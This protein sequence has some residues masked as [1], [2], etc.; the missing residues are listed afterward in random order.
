MYTKT[1]GVA[2]PHKFMR[3]YCDYCQNPVGTHAVEVQT[4]VMMQIS[5]NYYHFTCYNEVRKN[6]R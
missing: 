3:T 4:I 5:A 1:R 6:G 2:L